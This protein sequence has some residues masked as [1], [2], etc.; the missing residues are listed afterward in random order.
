MEQ[1][2]LKNAPCCPIW[3]ISRS[4]F[5]LRGFPV[6]LSLLTLDVYLNIV[7]APR[8][9]L[10]FSLQY[11]FDLTMLQMSCLEKAANLYFVSFFLW[12]LN[13]LPIQYLIAEW[14]FPIDSG[15]N[16]SRPIRFDSTNNL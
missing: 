11:S 2:H 9:V 15:D 10:G 13:Y 5:L 3:L 7:A 14:V 16:E 12:R 1:L 4:Y 6:F 8:V